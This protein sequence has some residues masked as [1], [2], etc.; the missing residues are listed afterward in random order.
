MNAISFHD[1]S[2]GDEP[3]RQSE[4]NLSITVSARELKGW[5][6]QRVKNCLARTIPRGKGCPMRHEAQFTPKVKTFRDAEA[7]EE[8][9]I[10]LVPYGTTRLRIAI[11]PLIKNKESI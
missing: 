9:K 7:G 5:K 11:F 10:R 2:V 4:N 6:L 3:W 8:S 1:G